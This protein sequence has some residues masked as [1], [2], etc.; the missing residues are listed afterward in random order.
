VVAAVVVAEEEEEEE[1]SLCGG[2]FSVGSA[3]ATADCDMQ[4]M[5]KGKTAKRSPPPELPRRSFIVA[6][7]L[8]GGGRE[9]EIKE[10]RRAGVG[11]PAS[12]LLEFYGWT[13][14]AAAG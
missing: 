10:Q 12:L 8:Q 4:P 1:G 9:L 5:E 6:F 3:T 2:F 14:L 13:A 11:R 7:D